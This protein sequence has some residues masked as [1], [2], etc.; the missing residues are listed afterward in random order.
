MSFVVCAET[1]TNPESSEVWVVTEKGAYNADNSELIKYEGKYYG[2]DGRIYL[3]QDNLLMQIDGPRQEQM[4][5]PQKIQ[6]HITV[7]PATSTPWL[8]VPMHPHFHRLRDRKP[9][10]IQKPS[11]PH[12]KR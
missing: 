4:E 10:S 5:Q 6:I 9:S 2:G 11:S 3:R 7:P 8:I 1:M 12:K